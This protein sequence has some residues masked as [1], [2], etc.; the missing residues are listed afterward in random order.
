MDPAR[1]PGHSCCSK[2]A[3]PAQTCIADPRETRF[4]GLANFARPDAPALLRAAAGRIMVR[5]RGAAMF[6]RDPLPFR[7]GLAMASAVN[8]SAG[9]QTTGRFIVLFSDDAGDVSRHELKARLGIEALG[10]NEYAAA[11]AGEPDSYGMA[12]I[13]FDELGVCIVNAPPDREPAMIAAVTDPSSPII[14]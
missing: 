10:A 2:V 6:D 12:S 1:A 9:S 7:G 5:D 11:A 13:M 14:A 3:K 4:S 8:D